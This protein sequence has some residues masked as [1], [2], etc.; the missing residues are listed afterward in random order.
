MAEGVTPAL[1]L[2]F[3]L[4]PLFTQGGVRLAQERFVVPRAVALG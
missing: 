4:F 2:F 3:M 1:F